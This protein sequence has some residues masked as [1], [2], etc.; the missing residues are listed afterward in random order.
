MNLSETLDFLDNCT[1]EDFI[2]YA[3]TFNIF[4]TTKEPN[5][6]IIRDKIISLL[7][8]FNLTQHDVQPYTRT[9]QGEVQVRNIK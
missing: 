6:I 5:Y 3:K 8:K 7:S 1:Q 4:K 9:V 2:N